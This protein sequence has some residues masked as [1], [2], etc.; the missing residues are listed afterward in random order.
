MKQR[1]RSL[2]GGDELTAMDTSKKDD[3]NDI[4]LHRMKLQSQEHFIEAQVQEGDTLQAI[5]LRFYCSVAELKRI[6]HIHKDNEIFARRT[7]KIPVTPYSIL[8][9]RLPVSIAQL[10]ESEPSTSTN[11]SS[12]HTVPQPNGPLQTSLPKNESS[13]NGDYAIDCNAVV[14]NSTLTPSVIPYTDAEEIE[15]VSEGTQLLPNKEKISVEAVVVK[16]LTSHGADFGLKWFHLVCC[17]IVMGVVIPI[18]YVLFY[19][20][21]PEHEHD[22]SS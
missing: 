2:H 5:A 7:V 10:S 11:V 21:K 19:L 13:T 14:M 16:E 4:Q 6:N 18:V 20:Q 17:M 12:N 1:T 22:Y 3:Y 8:T 9:E 15:T